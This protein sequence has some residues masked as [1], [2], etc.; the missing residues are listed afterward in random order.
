MSQLDLPDYS[1]KVDC[2]RYFKQ[3]RRSIDREEISR[4]IC[5]RL[6][7][8]PLLQTARTILAY[9]A[10][11]DEIDLSPLM[12]SWPDKTW[13]LPRTLPQYQMDWHVYQLGDTL[14]RAQWGVLE[15]DSNC[16]SIALELVDI[17]LVP[18]IACD[19]QGT[20]LGYGGG[21]Y[22]RCLASPHLQNALTVGVIP[23]ACWSE[24][25]LPYESWDV[26]LGAIVTED[27]IWVQEPGLAEKN[28]QQSGSFPLH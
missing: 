7:R 24:T 11:L 2:R 13:G 1:S 18:A 26:H 15:P 16:P 28:A 6:R 10:M 14:Q 9:W 12:R 19:R 4:Q 3:V 23:A 21:F 5:D 27:D 8:W 22:D 25:Q 20:R 17:V